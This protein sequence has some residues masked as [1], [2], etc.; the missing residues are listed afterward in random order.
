AGA[1]EERAAWK[2][3]RPHTGSPAGCSSRSHRH[4][5]WDTG[6]DTRADSIPRQAQYGYAGSEQQAP[7]EQNATGQEDEDGRVVV[8][9]VVVVEVVVVGGTQTWMPW[10]RHLGPD[11][12]LALRSLLAAMGSDASV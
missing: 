4:Y 10:C 6:L 12:R 3:L 1:G 5:R 11:L 8:V 2:T 7:V 9:V